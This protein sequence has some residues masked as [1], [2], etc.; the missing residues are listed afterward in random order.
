[1]TILLS[2]SLR[3]ASSIAVIVEAAAV[4]VGLVFAAGQVRAAKRLR[5]DQARQATEAQEVTLRPYVAAH[6]DCET[7]IFDTRL[8]IENLGRTPAYDVTF[9]VDPP[10][11]GTIEHPEE[12]TPIN[13][14]ISFLAPGQRVTCSFEMIYDRD[15]SLPSRWDLTVRYSGRGGVQFD[16]EPQVLD[17]SHYWDTAHSHRN[18]LH[19]IHEQLK[20]LNEAWRSGVKVLPGPDNTRSRNRY[21]H[22]VEMERARKARDVPPNHQ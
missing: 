21:E 5:E 9:E 11:A 2:I 20:K 10:L 18:G 22:Q 13:K 17:F 12:I 3:D 15:E 8:V 14:G 7:S 6:L 16:P 19:E 1:V 4:V